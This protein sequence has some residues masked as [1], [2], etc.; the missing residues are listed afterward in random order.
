MD[1]ASDSGSEGW[2]FESLPAYQKEEAPSGVSSFCLCRKD[3]KGRPERS[4]SKKVSGGH[5]FSPW[6]SPSASDAPPYPDAPS[7]KADTCLG[8][9]FFAVS[10]MQKGKHPIV[11]PFLW[12]LFV[13]CWGREKS[14]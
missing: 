7:Y 3:S 1:R 4:E 8:I 6:E 11:F 14:K 13:K 10:G 2:G 12:W 9:C 5:F